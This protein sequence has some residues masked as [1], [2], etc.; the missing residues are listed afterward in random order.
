MAYTQITP[1]DSVFAVYEGV[2]AMG[3]RNIDVPVRMLN[4]FCY[5]VTD[6]GTVVALV[7]NGLDN[8]VEAKTLPGYLDIVQGEHSKAATISVTARIYRMMLDRQKIQ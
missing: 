2:D 5:A 6:T 3:Q 1:V 7:D 4:V 8:F